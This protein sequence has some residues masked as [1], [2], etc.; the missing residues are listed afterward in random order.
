AWGLVGIIGGCF[1]F[2]PIASKSKNRGLRIVLAL[3]GF[4]LGLFYGVI[5][6]LWSWL[7]L[8]PPYTWEKFIFILSGS[9]LFDIAHGFTNFLF[10]YSFG[11]ETINILLRYKNRF[12]VQ[13]IPNEMILNERLN[14]IT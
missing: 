6:N 12:L 7:I 8:E 9:I 5:M 1:Q 2:L 14:N 11:H 13:V 3:V 4:I 10:L